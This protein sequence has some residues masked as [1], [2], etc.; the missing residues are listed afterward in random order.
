MVSKSR[1][2]TIDDLSNIKSYSD[3]Q[4]SPDGLAYSFVT[5]EMHEQNEYTS[6][7]YMQTLTDEEPV[8]WTS[9]DKKDSHPRFSPDGKYITF[10]SDRSGQSQI[11]LMP[12]N[13]GEAKQIT[14]FKDGA[15]QPHWTKDGKYILF[16][17]SLPQ[18]A[19]V[20]EQKEEAKEER[21]QRIQEEN[22]RPY[23]VNRLKYKSDGAGLH[24]EKKTQIILYD[25]T[26]KSFQQLTSKDRHHHFHDVSPCGSWI[27]FSTNDR[28]EEDYEQITDLFILNI[29]TGEL[30]KLTDSNGTY[31][32]AK[33]SP[34][35]KRIA[36]IGHDFSY[37]GATLNEL[38]V[39]DLESLKTLCLSEQWDLQIGDY[40]ISDVR[41][42]ASNTGPFWSSEENRLYFIGT[43]F[44]AT[45]LYEVTMDGTLKVIYE[46]NNHIYAAAYD[47]HHHQFLLGI[48]T[49]SDPCN[50]YLLKDNKLKRLTAAHKDFFKKIKLSEPE[51]LLIPIDD[52]LKIQG[53]LMRPPSFNEEKKYP[54]I[55]QIHGGPHVMYGQTFFHEMQLLA[56]KGFVVLYTNPRGSHGYGQSFVDAVRGH[57]GDVD[58]KDL[59]TA[60]DYALEKFPF[61]DPN[62]LGVTGGSY[63]GFMTNWIVG[64]TDRFQAAVTQRSISNWLSFYGVSDIGY[65]FTKWEHGYNLLEDPKKLWDFSPLKY[66]KQV[67]TPLLILHSE[68]DLRCP[69]EQAEQLFITLKHEKKEVEFVRFPGA[70]HNLSRTGDPFLRKERLK[71]IL[72]WF[73]KYL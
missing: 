29:H 54:F 13:G 1:G 41:L 60:V 11:W 69:I 51:E 32:Q 72:R 26:K 44:G 64:H 73:M 20:N 12:T 56:A 10:Q 40:M 58:Y 61:I 57:Y 33:F 49:P 42:G 39:T 9:H 3:P 16:S 43:D 28:K 55:L 2:I 62:R 14:H 35:G 53:W 6:H 15:H 59:M 52:E 68:E 36:F 7:L 19:K 71:H 24:D 37:K 38:Y 5:T 67:T 30:K 31:G 18:G 22:K 46:N 45:K 47:P 70:N 34:T 27:A 48:S 21:E 25:I 63:G 50:F 17:A 4:F 8:K 66:A 23:L 65:F